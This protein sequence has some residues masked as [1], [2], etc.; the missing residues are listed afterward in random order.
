VDAIVSIYDDM[1]TAWTVAMEAIAAYER[2]K[3]R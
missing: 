2:F 3:F 1:L